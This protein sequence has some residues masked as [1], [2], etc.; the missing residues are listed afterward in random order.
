MLNWSAQHDWLGRYFVFER[1]TYT[2]GA[3]NLMWIW[4]LSI[5]IRN[6]Y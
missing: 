6:F 5:S 2:Q 1:A 4:M 3:L